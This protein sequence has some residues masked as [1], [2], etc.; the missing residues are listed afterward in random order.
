MLAGVVHNVI[1]F[2]SA[3]V[4]KSVGSRIGRSAPDIPPHA[5]EQDACRDSGQ[6]RSKQPIRACRPTG[7][8][9]KF[10]R[11]I[12]A[13]GRPAPVGDGR[14]SAADRAG[15]Q[16][17]AAAGRLHGALWQVRCHESLLS[18][19]PHRENGQLDQDDVTD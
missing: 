16:R 17:A 10:H 5:K 9:W 11:H 1:A 2:R 19:P 8:D 12:L 15:A 14:P 4:P 3:S 13:A 7:V 6:H 18:A